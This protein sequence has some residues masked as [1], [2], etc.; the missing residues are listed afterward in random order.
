MNRSGYG[1]EVMK[2]PFDGQVSRRTLDQLTAAA[3]SGFGSRIGRE[4]VRQHVL[5]GDLLH[6]FRYDGMAVGFGSYNIYDVRLPA[7]TAAD[8][9][10]HDAQQSAGAK[11]LYLNGT[12]VTD[13]FKSRS[14]VSNSLDFAISYD[15]PRYLALRTQS[16]V[17]YYV[18]SKY[19]ITSPRCHGEAPG[20]EEKAVGSFIA[21]KLCMDNYEPELFV[22]R[23]TYGKSL[24]GIPVTIDKV[25][26][27]RLFDDELR[28]DARRWRLYDS[29]SG[30]Q[31]FEKALI[32]NDR[33]NN[34]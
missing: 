23:G 12:A 25:L 15:S 21:G 20:L 7:G 30:P 14:F 34:N 33:P 24:Y 16:K 22:E 1:I 4:D 19:G 10:H 27:N 11:V 29:G 2:A 5:S 32:I 8:G 6:I 3:R 13:D 26:V 28:I 9:Q 31:G 17:M 18:A